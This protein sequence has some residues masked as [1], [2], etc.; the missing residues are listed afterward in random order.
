MPAR[1]QNVRK[2]KP[3][4]HPVT[5]IRAAVLWC[6]ASGVAVRLGIAGAGWGVH[7]VNQTKPKWERDPRSSGVNPLGAALLNY[8]PEAGETFA[9]AAECL[10]APEYW[11]RAFEAGLNREEFVTAWSEASD[12]ELRAAAYEA[13]IRYREELIRTRPAV[14]V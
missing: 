4:P 5:L 1:A 12:R 7:C 8:Q 3:T 14:V 2:E 13:G 6:R 10:F 9:A 11:I